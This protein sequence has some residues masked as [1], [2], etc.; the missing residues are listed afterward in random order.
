MKKIAG[1]ALVG[2]VLLN[3]LPGY[4]QSYAESALLFSRVRPGGSARI[5]GMGGAQ[6]SLGGDYSSAVSNPA[7]LG[8]YNRSEFTITP[9]LNMFSSKSDYQGTTTPASKTTFEIPGVSLVIHSA[10]EGPMGFLGGSFAVTYNRLNDFNRAYS[11]SGTNPNNSIIDFFIQDATGYGP[12]TLLPGGNYSNTPTALGY[13]NFLIEDNTFFDPNSKDS[14]NYGTNLPSFNRVFQREDIKTSGSQNQVSFAYGANFSDKLFIGVG[15]GVT[16]LNFQST[17]TFTE[18]QFNYNDP[19]DPRGQP[20]NNIVLT[21]GL[22]TNGSG[23]NGSIGIV[24]RPITQ[25]QL[26]FS[27]NTPSL[28]L[29][30][31]NYSATMTTDWNNY[32][33]YGNGSRM[34]NKEG[35]QTDNVVTDYNLTTPSRTNL[36]ATF[37]FGKSGFITGDVEFVNYPGAN[38]SPSTSDVSFDADNADIKRLYKSTTNFRVGGEYRLKSFRARLGYSFMPDPYQ[39][40]QNG[41]GDDITSISGGLG[42]RVS[43]FFIDGTVIITNGNTTY[44]PYNI[45]SVYSPL[46]TNKN[47]TNMVMVTVGFPF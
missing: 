15:L 24:Y 47:T 5:Q 6:V 37:F 3:S 20:L 25:V 2:L 40:T 39:S 23:I 29:L 32:D 26:G 34:L 12:S 8:M 16:S 21:E 22:R 4:A 13:N 33:Y 10:K 1:L 9:G 11:Y 41:V 17:K 31:D 30:T 42:Y 45:N 38:Y 28:Y 14:L 46:V 19:S 27:Y 18:S 44:R 35:A 36:G 7:G 43:K